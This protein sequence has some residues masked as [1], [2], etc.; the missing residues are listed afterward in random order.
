MVHKIWHVWA[1]NTRNKI[2]F[3]YRLINA[4]L[5]KYYTYLEVFVYQVEDKLI[6]HKSTA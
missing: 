4:L 2:Y 1:W 5:H 6:K 3:R